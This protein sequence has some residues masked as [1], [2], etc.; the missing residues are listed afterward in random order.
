M[1]LTADVEMSLSDAG[2]IDFY[3]ARQAAFKAV[4]TRSYAFAYENVHPTGLPVRKDDVATSLIDALVINQDLRDELADKKLRQRFWYQRFADLI[5]D[6]L[7]K[8]LED[9]HSAALGN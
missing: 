6:R 2:L 8:D 7:W 1:G 5:L 3:D 4:A 9:E